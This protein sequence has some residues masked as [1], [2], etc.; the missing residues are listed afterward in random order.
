MNTL[1]TAKR[2]NV[3]ATLVLSLGVLMTGWAS[4]WLA[5]FPLSVDLRWYL[6]ILAAWL[7]HC[8]GARVLLAWW[9]LAVVPQVGFR[10]WDG[11]YVG[12]GVSSTTLL[13][14]ICVAIAFDRRSTP[15]ALEDWI[16]P[17]WR[18]AVQLAF[19]LLVL[20]AIDGSPIRS[21]AFGIL[22]HA[23]PSAV[24]FFG[25]IRWRALVRGLNLPILQR[26]PH[27]EWGVAALA[28]ALV[29]VAVAVNF[30][31]R[32]K[33]WS[34]SLGSAW[35]GT[36]IPVLCFALVALGYARRGSIIAM[37][38]AGL[39]ADRVLVYSVGSLGDF[40]R[41]EHDWRM[42]HWDVLFAGFAAALV[43]QIL[44]PFFKGEAFGPQTPQRRVATLFFILAA[45]LFGNV[46]ATGV[47]PPA[48]GA[49]LWI[50][51][52]IAFIAG[53][54]GRERGL[55]FAPLFILFLWL[56][57]AASAQVAGAG[58]LSPADKIASIGLV[59][60]PFA[61]CGAL[62][63]MDKRLSPVGL[64]TL[65]QSLPAPNDRVTTVDISPL[66][67][68]IEQVD[69]SI[70]WRS[71][72]VAA[73]PFLVLWGL[74]ETYLAYGF[75]HRFSA[76][77][78]DGL[79]FE[80]WYFVLGGLLA[81]APLAFALWDW[82][83]RQD[84]LRLL[85][86]ASGSAVGAV[87]MMAVGALLGLGV[88][89]IWGNLEE[90]LGFF[91]VAVFLL[92]LSGV[93]LLASQ[94]ATRTVFR[95]MG[96]IGAAAVLG[97]IGWLGIEEGLEGLG[98]I[99]AALG[100]AILLGIFLA[101]FVRLRLV[102]AGDRPRA[103]IFGELRDKGFWVRMAAAAGLPS[104]HWQ[105]AALRKPAFWALLGARPIVYAGMVLT[106]TWA[107]IGVAVAVLGHFAFHGGKRLA[108]REMWRPTSAP[109]AERHVL[110]LRGFDDDHCDFGRPRWNLFARWLDLW[111]FRRN[112]DEAMIDE[113]AQFG[114]VVALGRPG[115][116][117]TPFGAL[118]HYSSDKDWQNT[119]AKAA[120]SARA[121]V[122][123][124]SDSPG[125]QWEYDLL[126]RE[127]LLGKVLVL[128][129]PGSAYLECNRRAVEWY[130]PGAGELVG[131]MAEVGQLPVAMNQRAEGT[132][133]MTTDSLSAA[134]YVLALR[135]HFHAAPG[136]ASAG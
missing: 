17:G 25:A 108:A 86:A 22:L 121:I 133:L 14:S 79:S 35:V 3:S 33:S 93:G 98:K 2:G 89:E 112:A 125:V 20:A 114:L 100:A 96:G 23:I 94:G 40:L 15:L 39:L 92:I 120:R 102:L 75:A 132:L 67:R 59:T 126:K 122:L 109:A 1:P 43:A 77:F 10:L 69:R 50:L 49:T 73:A 80:W 97:A 28:A 63:S 60:F 21:G 41:L 82:L 123:V 34:L 31:L 68:V 104:S 115:D 91:A 52:V 56:L 66:A 127:Q 55:F 101:R 8:Y 38:V 46:L 95:V 64:P 65:A 119:L 110:F 47:S 29:V 70:T 90:G 103:L 84:S 85:A 19:C 13:L 136:S 44:V 124:A 111:S 30:S 99:S 76:L 72:F 26:R 131:Q 32:G 61:F 87:A 24:I 83:D 9:P 7:G 62:G 135:L 12:F 54:D 45:I 18:L 78:N 27:L 48:Y 118:R 36:L 51:S 37:L 128:F 57:A 71:F 116:K 11:P 113:I 74:G 58:G 88:K 53:A 105:R 106:R 6:P 130:S 107:L 42:L 16:R 81:L 4:L 117:R 129:R 5:G 134:A